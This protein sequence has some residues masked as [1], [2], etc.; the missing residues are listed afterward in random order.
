MITGSNS[1]I[2]LQVALEVAKRGGVIHMVCRNQEAAK[3]APLRNHHH[4]GNDKIHLHIVDLAKPR[5]VV[6]WVERFAAQHDQLH[7]LVNNAGC[8]VHER[9]MDEDG[10]ET[11]FA[12][13][14][15]SVHII[16]TTLAPLLMKSEEA[17]VV[18]VSSAGMLTV[19]L[20]PYDLMHLNLNPGTVLS[21]THRIKDNRL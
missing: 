1:G 4:T 13:N 2:G 5:E 11:N 14:T 8:M 3:L 19:R 7:V 17:R 16:T 15:L 18:T 9:Q 20:D 10:V 6:L 12:V 21:C